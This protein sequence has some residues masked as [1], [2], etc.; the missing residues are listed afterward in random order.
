MHGLHLI[1]LSLIHKLRLADLKTMKIKTG[2]TITQTSIVI[3]LIISLI[4]GIFLYQQF[5][6]VGKSNQQLLKYKSTFLDFL[7]LQTEFSLYRS[8]NISDLQRE[9]RAL[10]M[11]E[12]VA[13]KQRLE[14]DKVAVLLL[15]QIQEGIVEFESNLQEQIKLQ[16]R[17]GF[18][19]DNGLRGVFRRTVHTLQ[20]TS[21][22]LND[23]D[24]E[25]L[26]LEMR[27]REKDYLL[28]WQ[29]SYQDMHTQL[30]IQTRALISAKYPNQ[31]DT[32]ITKLNNYAQGFTQY[33]YYLEIQGQNENQGLMG[34]NAQLKAFLEKRFSHLS[35]HISKE[36]TTTVQNYLKWAFF[37]ILCTTLISLSVSFVINRRITFSLLNITKF[38][39]KFAAEDDFNARLKLGGND[40]LAQFSDDLNALLHH[41]ET[42]LERLTLA[43]QRLVQDAKMA[44]IGVMVK[45]FAH[46][47]NTP[48]GVAITSESFLREKVECL[49][50]NFNQGKISKANLQQLLQEFDDSL[51]LLESNLIRSANLIS[52]FKKVA[53]HQEYDELVEFDIKEFIDN[54]LSSLRHEIDKHNAVVS[55][56]I[57]SGMMLTSYLGAFSQV[58]TIFIIN[59]LRHAKAPDR[60]L[61]IEITCKFV[62]GAIHFRYTDDGVGIKEELLDKVFEP[63]VTTKRGKGGTGLGLSIVYNLITQRLGGQIKLQSIEDKGVC[64]YLRFNEIAFRQNFV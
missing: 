21:S 49:K 26:V 1:D 39:R 57:P 54:L 44:S 35:D 17:L 24:F 3:S 53:S 30:V 27:R 56:D 10:Y 18:E 23:K 61:N 43:Q 5:V 51:M 25:I 28:R 47:I 13:L 34:K 42:L 22:E 63:F 11:V 45:G 14:Q 46:E 29:P 62:S 31:S 8:R 7:N 20:K 48:L 40:E 4:C 41:V 50:D 32:L 36:Q 38:V 64:I 60:L 55:V 19:E 16:L 12:Y 6:F 33:I 15:E 59:S 2:F 58:F 37:V 52:S 9:K